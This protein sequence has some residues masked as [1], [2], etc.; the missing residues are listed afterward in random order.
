M[1]EKEDHVTILTVLGDL[2]QLRCICHTGG[3]NVI[4]LDFRDSRPIY[5]QVKDELRKLVIKGV[6]ETDEKLPSVRELA[7]SL[8]INPNTIQR[9]YRDLEQEGFLY[10]V[11]GKGSF[12]AEHPMPDR[13][14]IVALYEQLDHVLEELSFLQ[15]EEEQVMEHVT[16]Y[17]QNL[18]GG[19][20]E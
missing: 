11:A 5:E 16:A 4:H 10:T 17:Y 2:I 6:L 12:V 8:A 18:S 3:D 7:G 13:G 20:A 15:E 14:K 1:T 9:A 19:N